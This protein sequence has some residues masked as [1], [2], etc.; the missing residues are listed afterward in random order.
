MEIDKLKSKVEQLTAELDS[1]KAVSEVVDF[2][3]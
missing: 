3:E 2:R 1:I